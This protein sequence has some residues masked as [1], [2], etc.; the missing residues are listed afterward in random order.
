[1]WPFDRRSRDDL[2][3]RGE[4]LARKLLTKQGR[5]ILARNYRCP[6]GEID[7]IALDSSTRRQIGAETLCFVEVKTRSSDRYASPVSAVNA[8]KQKRMIKAANY[9]LTQ[10]DTEK[11]NVRFDVV[12][13]VIRENAKP[14]IV[15]MEDAFR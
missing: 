4:R 7:L 14:E 2:G 13:V 10:H 15:Y 8:D 1:M 6:T 5:K 9:Y 12:T 11:L 3:Q